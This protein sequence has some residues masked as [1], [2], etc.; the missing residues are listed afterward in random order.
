M[1]GLDLLH[2]P[3]R[4][5]EPT[6]AEQWSTTRPSE[7]TLAAVATSVAPGGHLQ[8]RETIRRSPSSTIVGRS[9]LHSD[10]A[11]EEVAVKL[12]GSSAASMFGVRE[13]EL[14]T[15]LAGE[16]V[17]GLPRLHFGGRI[18]LGD[19][20]WSGMVLV[21]EWL[22]GS[23]RTAR[24][25]GRLGVVDAEGSGVRSDRGGLSEF[26][27]E[28]VASMVAGLPVFEA[29]PEARARLVA[30]GRRD[31][32][33]PGT[34]R[35]LR[36]LPGAIDEVVAEPGLPRLSRTIRRCCE[37]LA[38]PPALRSRTV[39]HGDYRLGNAVFD[40]TNVVG[41]IDWEMWHTGDA[42]LDLG[43]LL[44]RIEHRLV[45][46]GDLEGR[47][48]AIDRLTAGWI[49]AVPPE[50]GL[51][52]QWEWFAAAGVAAQ[53]WSATQMLYRRQAGVDEQVLTLLHGQVERL[54][55]CTLDEVRAAM[56]AAQRGA[57]TFGYSYEQL[58]MGS[59]PEDL[60]DPGPPLSQ[61]RTQ[62]CDRLDA[63]VHDMRLPAPLP[64]TDLGLERLHIVVEHMARRLR[65]AGHAI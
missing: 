20:A 59:D 50:S 62:F 13:V 65:A 9:T 51:D 48:E 55:S 31:V 57:A 37:A 23:D 38:H 16:A 46:S 33:L 4:P 61:R 25:V 28:C 47:P 24:P 41:L 53:L 56:E 7:Q 22:G 64:A 5:T 35:R 49:E 45:A 26:D 6:G 52:E 43:Y 1:N 18:D 3:V 14:Y 36:A 58:G 21:T 8:W 42:R 27:I 19:P 63:A 2:S 29:H 39:C 54:R 15:T 40:G 34:L 30:L 44:G 17:P 60:P 10:R 12:F 32:C 11:A